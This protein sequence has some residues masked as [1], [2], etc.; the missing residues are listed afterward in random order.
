MHTRHY[1]QLLSHGNLHSK[2]SIPDTGLLAEY[3]ELAQSA[4]GKH[5]QRSMCH[6]LGRLF[7]GYHNEVKGTNTCRFIHPREMEPNRKATYVRVVVADRPRKTEPRQ[8]C[9]TVGGDRVDYYGTRRGSVLRGRSATTTCT[10]VAFRLGSISRGCMKRHVL[11][12]LTS[13]W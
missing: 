13:L 2:R 5:W 11:V 6:E 12:P 1:I 10:Y 9:V 4:D 7:Q 3:H 8:V